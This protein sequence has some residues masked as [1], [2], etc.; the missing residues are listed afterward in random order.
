MLTH[1]EYCKQAVE[2]VKLVD[3]DAVIAAW[4]GSL[5]TRNLP[6]RSAFGSYVVLQNFK[7]HEFEMSEHFSRGCAYCGLPNEVDQT[8]R[9][10]RIENYPFQVQHMDIQYGVFDLATF[11][12]RSVD[13]PTNADVDCLKRTLAN[14]RALPPSAQLSELNKSLQGVLK[15]NKF[16]RMILLETLGYAGILC[17]DG[18]RQYSDNFVGYEFANL[19]QPAQ[20][21]KREWSYP[22]RFW[23]GSDGVNEAMVTHYFGRFI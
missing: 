15:S 9:P 4:L 16:E 21:F 6:A 22:V 13:A 10:E 20:Y 23:T 14:I 12:K 19:Q 3:R 18:R 17:P 5:S 2:I 8:D 11:H 1:D 7:T